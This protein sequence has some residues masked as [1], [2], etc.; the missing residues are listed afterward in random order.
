MRIL[1]YTGKGGVGKTSIAAATA[2]ALA[3]QGK[4]VLIMSTDQAHSLGDAFAM[5]LGNVPVPVTDHLDALEIDA[6][7]ESRKA[8]GSL[9]DYLRQIVQDRANGGLAADEVLIFPGLEELCSLLRILNIAEENLYDVLVVDCAPTGETLSLLRYPEQLQVLA[10]RILLSVRSMNR[11]F[12]G[13]ISKKTSVPKPRDAVFDEFEQLTKD[14]NR[15]REIMMDR[16]HSSLRLVMTP[17]KIVLEE[18]RRCYTWL[19]VYDYGVDA[20]YVNRIFPDRALD[21]YFA[22]W[23]ELQKESLKLAG[24]SFPNQKIFLLE[25]QDG[26]IRGIAKLR[27]VSRILYGE[28]DPAQLYCTEQAFRM[29]DVQGTRNFIVRLPWMEEEDIQVKKEDGDLILT[30]RNETR[31]FHL[32][33]R[34]SRRYVSGWTYDGEELTIHMDY[35]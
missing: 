32:S 15:L 10:D 1:F 17:E 14:L 28:E 26:E 3:E 34:V 29:E 5:K 18:A 11:A 4:K 8:W 21:G 33:D 19:Q 23:A 24:E 13:L 27:E 25:L 12:G 20:V 9:R 22:A 2:V 16:Q 7:E 31:R 35:D 30:V 6:A